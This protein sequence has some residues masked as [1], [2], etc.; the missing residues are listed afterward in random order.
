M[1]SDNNLSEKITNISD[2]LLYLIKQTSYISINI[3]LF[4]ILALFFKAFH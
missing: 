1:T 4:L 2:K 3:H